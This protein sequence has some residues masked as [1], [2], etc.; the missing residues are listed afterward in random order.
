MRSK[1]IVY[2]AI[3]F[4]NPPRLPITYCNRDFEHS[5]TFSIGY[6]P[7]R[8]FAPA[9]PGMTEWGYEWARLD[10]T[11]GQPER[12]PLADLSR[13]ADYVPP[14]PTAP[15]R[16]DHLPEGVAS[17]GDK[18]IKFGL[19][20]TG[21]NQATFLRGFE[22]FLADLYTDRRAAERVLGIVF[23]FEIGLI[24]QLT[25]HEIDAV[26]FADDWGTQA[27]LMISPEL[28]RAVF[29]PRYAEQFERVHRIGKK[30]WFHT[31]GN[32][33]SIIADLID[34]GVD[35]LELLQPD[36]LGV[37]NLARDFGGKV[38]FCCSVDHQRVAISGTREEIFAYAGKLA[39]TLGV[40]KGG[41]LAYIEDYACLGMSEQNYQWIREAFHGLAEGGG[42][43]CH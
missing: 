26:Q 9:R 4:G 20:I 24:E 14:S 6:G 5:D 37:E 39:D 23:D 17:H 16:L 36:L 27:G 40:F 21:F 25:E 29:R 10:S 7:A 22:E 42:R 43:K 3:E 12:R 18:F 1:E 33:Y 13:L 34:I 41:F 38:C 8:D 11:M 28:W 30:V 35:V 31:C 2:R 15:G 19:G 32:V